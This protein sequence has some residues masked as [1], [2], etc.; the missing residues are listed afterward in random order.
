MKLCCPLV[1]G[2]A[3]ITAVALASLLAQETP[4]PQNPMAN[5]DHLKTMAARVG[6]L[7]MKYASGRK[8]TALHVFDRPVM[9]TG[10]KEGNPD[11]AVW[12]W[13]DGQ[14]PVGA[15][16][17]WNRGPLWYSEN[18]AIVGEVLE[19]T[20]WPNA[21]WRSNGGGRKPMALEDSVPESPKS[22]QRTLRALALEF[23]AREDRLG[24]KS[25]LRLFPRP[26]Y[27]YPDADHD[28][29][30]GAVF[31]FVY[32]TD[33]EVLMQIEARQEGGARR[34]EVQFARMASAEL[35][36]KLRE[37]EIWSVPAISRE[38][39]VKTNADY[40]IIREDK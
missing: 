10:N 8:P 34:W 9:R 14:R 11:G 36:V 12:L 31:A 2:F 3:V 27:E 21:T 18:T 26:I 17:V 16:C 1:G 40:C 38:E 7:S 39:V 15:L 37:K 5:A 6:R 33:P 25:E 32:G 30:G 23:T 35:S 24:I 28:T 4:A 13:L 19:V 29:L 20:G 22:R